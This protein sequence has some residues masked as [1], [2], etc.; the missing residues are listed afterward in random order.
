MP[1][2]LEIE[3]DD[4]DVT[5]LR[6]FGEGTFA[7]AVAAIGAGIARAREGGRRRLLIDAR[8]VDGFPPPGI[9]ERHWMIREWVA[10]AD[11]RM[12]L[13]FVVVPS[14]IDPERYGVVAARNFGITADVFVDE[15]AARG[16]L[17]LDA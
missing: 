14:L 16:W 17:R 1:V 13:A 7:Q 2:T 11:A 6:A 3:H 8:E 10:V 15:D 9:G 5:T 12:R 4:A